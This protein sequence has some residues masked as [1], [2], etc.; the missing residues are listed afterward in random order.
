MSAGYADSACKLNGG[1]GY[2]RLTEK[3][4]KGIQYISHVWFCV[5]HS[6]IH[7]YT[8]GTF[9]NEVAE[10]ADILHQATAKS[11]VIMDELGRGTSTYDGYIV[12]V[13]YT[14]LYSRYRAR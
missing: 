4:A 8:L 9:M 11:L 2:E 3:V 13:D 14:V 7:S 5:I 10:C 1:T 6:F 12:R